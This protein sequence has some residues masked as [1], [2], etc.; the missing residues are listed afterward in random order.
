[1]NQ[2]KHTETFDEVLL[3]HVEMCYSV[4]LAL[5][6]NPHRA[7]DLA[8]HVLTRAWRLRDNLDGKKDIKRTLLKALRRR[9]L[10]Y[11]CQAPYSLGNEENTVCLG[12]NEN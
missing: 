3:S 2:V 6:C 10:H 8:S 7:Q 11:Y 5:T 4:A 1:M 9:F 12:A